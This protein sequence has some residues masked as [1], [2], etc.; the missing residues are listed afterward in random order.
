MNKH[1]ILITLSALVI[2]LGISGCLQDKQN[3]GEYYYAYGD[4]ITRATGCCGLNF[5]GSDSYII[6]MR[7]KYDVNK[8]ADHNFNG[9][10]Q[11]STWGLNNLHTHYNPGNEY[12]IFMFGVNDC[13]KG[14]PSL[15]VTA[16][17]LVEIYNRTNANGSTPVLCIQTLV[18]HSSVSYSIQK[19]R[20]NAT[21]SLCETYSI[22]Y[23]KMFDAIDSVPWNGELDDW[24]SDFFS[25]DNIHP[26]VL[27][28]K[29]MSRFLWFF[30][31]EDDYTETYYVN[32]DTIVV[33]VD[34]N[35]TIYIDK[36]SSWNVSDI[37]VNCTTKNT[38]IPHII[39][40]DNKIHFL[41]LK[42][43]SYEITG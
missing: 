16:K 31:N 6:Q 12:F 4:S 11:T 34:Y 27:G 13:I 35:Q 33:S 17:N 7:N 36:H 32:N 10:G 23:V 18:S 2:C 38:I 26:D 24:N 20:I 25:G 43:C 15:S 21:I 29:E 41:G 30:I 5:D 8:S 1:L 22:P 37:I 39:G 42:G 3:Q 14:E 40:Y 28:H 9:G 19:L